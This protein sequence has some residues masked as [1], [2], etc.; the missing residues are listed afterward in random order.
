MYVFLRYSLVL[1]KRWFWLLLLGIVFCGGAAIVISLLLPATYEATTL[2]IINQ[3][4]FTSAY[5]NTTASVLAVPTYAPLLTAP[6]VLDP[7]VALHPGMSLQQLEGMIAVNPESNT[8]IIT[9]S[10][11][12]SNP[13]TA[14]Q[15]ANEIGQSFAI[16]LYDNYPAKA[17][18][19]DANVPIAPI[20]AK[21]LSY[22]AVG[23]VVGL[24]LA[25]TLIT[26]FEWIDDLP[27]S[28]EEVQEL[29]DVDILTA[30]PQLLHQSRHTATL[31]E[32]NSLLA[33]G[34]HILCAN[35]NA[36]QRLQ[37]CKLVMITSSLASEGKSTIVAKLATQ[38]AISGKHVLLIDANLRDPVQHSYFHLDNE[39]GL[40]N[41]LTENALQLEEALYGQETSIPQLWVLTAGNG[42]SNPADLLQ[43]SRTTDLFSYFQQAPFDYVLFDT[44]PLLSVADAQILSSHVQAT[45]LVVDLSHTAR[46]VLTRTRKVLGRLH[47][48]MLG[49]VLNRSLSTDSSNLKLY[50]HDMQTCASVDTLIPSSQIALSE[51]RVEYAEGT[52]EPRLKVTHNHPQNT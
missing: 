36:V 26:I 49:I 9:L 1:V 17:Q 40:G 42:F 28:A 23:S 3:K 5:D 46:R 33:E 24:G 52:T 19:V 44:P 7:V 32:E 25:L 13:K 16:Y 12:N 20:N 30:I 45:V 43:S 31:S 50:V 21:P 10:V 35:L 37:P 8:Q 22:G 39:Y 6:A 51:N 48:T 41:I 2:L 14:A 34:C 4:S 15:L 38:L 18:V 27:K 47:P 29:L 11:K